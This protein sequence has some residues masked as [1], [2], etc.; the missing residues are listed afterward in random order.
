MIITGEINIDV[1]KIPAPVM[2]SLGRGLLKNIREYFKNPENQ[3]AF[4]E[5]QRERG[6]AGHDVDTAAET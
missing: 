3:R 5:W 6:E 1:K 2:E 4:E